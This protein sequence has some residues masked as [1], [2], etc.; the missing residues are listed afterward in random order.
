MRIRHPNI[1][2]TIAIIE[3]APERA[4]VMELV[5]G[6]DLSQVL[7]DSGPLPPTQ[8]VEVGRGLGEALL[9]LDSLALCRIDLKPSNIVAHPTRG[10]VIVDLGIAR[11]T[12]VDE[13]DRDTN[14][15]AMIGTPAYMAPE[16]LRSAT[17]ADIR[18]DLYALGVVLYQCLTGRPPHGGANAVE[19]IYSILREPISFEGLTGSPALRDVVETCLAH[20]PLDRYQNP[21]DFLRALASTPE[22]VSRRTATNR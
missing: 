18:S 19:V 9:Y 14:A 4:L 5:E 16:Q 15:G 12:E 2:R 8:V 3:A 20:N 1:A 22:A 21:S 17:E 13:N 6:P 10:L 11:W 7:E